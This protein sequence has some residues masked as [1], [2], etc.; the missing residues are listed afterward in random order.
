M[1]WLKKHE[2]VHFTRNFARN[3]VA[4]NLSFIF[5]TLF[6]VLQLLCFSVLAGT[7]CK[8]RA[9]NGETQSS[10][11]KKKVKRIIFNLEDLED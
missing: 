3:F 10:S 2:K 5:K 8:I 11:S 6:E 9:M 7:K 4:A 1:L